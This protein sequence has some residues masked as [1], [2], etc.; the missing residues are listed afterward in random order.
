MIDLLFDRRFRARKKWACL[1][2]RGEAV[3]PLW[4][5]AGL[6][7]LSFSLLGCARPY[8]TFVAQAHDRYERSL[9]L[10]ARVEPPVQRR[11]ARRS[12]PRRAQSSPRSDVVTGSVPNYQMEPVTPGVGTPA[13]KREQIYSERRERELKRKIQSICANC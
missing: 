9:T 6:M 2:E 12:S 7:A 3:S 5:V 8:E 11:A 10:S 13:W 4:V 1:E